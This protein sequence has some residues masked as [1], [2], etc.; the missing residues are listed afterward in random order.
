MLTYCTC[1]PELPPELGL[2]VTATLVTLP[3][4]TVPLPLDTAQV[5]PAEVLAIVTL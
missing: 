5:C 4:P 1:S 2:Q 3:D